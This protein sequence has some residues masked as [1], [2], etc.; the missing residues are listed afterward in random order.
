MTI[1]GIVQLSTKSDKN[2]N[3]KCTKKGLINNFNKTLL[4]HI[5]HAESEFRSF[6]LIICKFII[7]YMKRK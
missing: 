2:W 7:V 3:L 1:G 5:E 6:E 4:K